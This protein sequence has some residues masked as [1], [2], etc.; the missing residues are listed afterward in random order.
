MKKAVVLIGSSLLLV[1][2]IVFVWKERVEKKKE[3]GKEKTFSFASEYH[4]L[5]SRVS[6]G[7]GIMANGEVEFRKTEGGKENLYFTPQKRRTEYGNGELVVILRQDL[8]C[9]YELDV[10]SKTYVKKKMSFL[11][12][13][14]DILPEAQWKPY[15]N[16]KVG[17]QGCKKYKYAAIRTDRAG[18]LLTC[19]VNSSGVPVQ[20]GYHTLEGV[21]ENERY[22]D[23]DQLIKI[24]SYEPGDQN[25][26]LFEVPE[27][28]KE[29]QLPEEKPFH[30]ERT[31]LQPGDQVPNFTLMGADGKEHSLDDFKSTGLVLEWTNDECPY[32]KKFYE[33]G[34]IQAIQKEYFGK[35]KIGWFSICSSPKDKWGYLSPEKAAEFQKKYESLATAYLID[36][37]GEVGKKYGVQVTPHVFVINHGKLVYSGAID[38]MPTTEKRY[39]GKIKNYLR[40][41]LQAI[42]EG[43]WPATVMVSP[44]G[45]PIP[46]E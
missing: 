20:V 13:A 8:G 32:V 1:G 29:I 3:E 45:S 40:L 42:C 30:A 41:A 23:V 28:F 34:E 2:V 14:F 31:G 33:S 11:E 21:D 19:W 35:M 39:A 10:S 12:D 25:P 38:I 22:P 16:E 36:V 37:T 7:Y 4:L 9:K 17:N 6:Q 43:R 44:Y 24:T 26:K 5:Y 18:F 15:E 27:D 46:Y